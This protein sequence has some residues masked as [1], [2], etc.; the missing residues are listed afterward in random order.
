MDYLLGLV[1]QPLTT[2]DAFWRQ[3]L[4]ACYQLAQSILKVGSALPE[5][6]GQGRWVVAPLW[7]TVHGGRCSRL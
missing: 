5:R 3:L 4:A 1:L 6:V 2:D 7:L